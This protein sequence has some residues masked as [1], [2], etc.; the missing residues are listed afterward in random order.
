MSPIFSYMV[1][2]LMKENFQA[3][4]SQSFDKTFSFNIHVKVEYLKLTLTVELVSNTSLLFRKLYFF[5]KLFKLTRH[6]SHCIKI[7]H[8]HYLFWIF[9]FRKTIF[10]CSTSHALR[11]YYLSLSTYIL[12][13]FFMQ[14][15]NR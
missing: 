10:P 6:I 5:Q 7:T 12:D 9:I 1:K 11:L 15:D 14:A 13:G 2:T 8:I 3:L 4:Q